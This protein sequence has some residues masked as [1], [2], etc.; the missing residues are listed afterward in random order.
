MVSITSITP[1]CSSRSS[2]SG[3]L[4]SKLRSSRL[5]CMRNAR[6]L[7]CFFISSKQ[8]SSMAY[9]FTSISHTFAFR[10]Q[11]TL[12]NATISSFT[13]PI[14]Y[15]QRRVVSS[16][17]IHQLLQ[18]RRRLL[19]HARKHLRSQRVLLRQR[20]QQLQVSAATMRD[21]TETD[22]AARSA[23]VSPAAE[24]S[25][26][27]QTASKRPPSQSVAQQSAVIARL[28][29]ERQAE[30]RMSASEE[31]CLVREEKETN[32]SDVQ[33]KLDDFRLPGDALVVLGILPVEQLVESETS[34]ERVL[35]VCAAHDGKKSVF[36]GVTRVVGASFFVLLQ[37][38]RSTMKR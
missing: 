19:R 9:R 20:R 21:F 3:T 13:L 4:L 29:R 10:R 6:S 32:E 33:E 1:F 12:I 16:A 31:G 18:Q 2:Q 5:P 8:T 38:D 35:L 15:L 22:S 11:R 36:K 24:R 26:S 34:L 30:V 17:T 25:A 28:A 27:S 37:R 23:G 7:P 14:R